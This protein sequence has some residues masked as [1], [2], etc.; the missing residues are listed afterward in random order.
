M[1]T[2]SAFQAMLPVW[3]NAQ[4][5]MQHFVRWGNFPDY[6]QRLIEHTNSFPLIGRWVVAVTREAGQVLDTE[7][8]YDC[9]QLHD[10]GEPLTGGDEHAYNKTADKEQREWEA[11]RRLTAGVPSVLQTPWRRAFALQYVRKP[12]VLLP[13]PD[14]SLVDQLRKTHHAEAIVFECSERIDYL[15]SAYDGWTR[16]VQTEHET[17]I[18]HAFSRQAPKLDGLIKE[19]PMLTHVWT[20]DLRQFLAE[21]CH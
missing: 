18:A 11:F 10:H 7:L 3:R 13:E 4:D 20:P 6:G 21:K 19:L 16:G 1:S 8:L 14:Q 15:F 2:A 5:P 9:F 12:D 17:M